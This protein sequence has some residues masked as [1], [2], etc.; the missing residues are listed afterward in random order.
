[1]QK[2]ESIIVYHS[3]QGQLSDEFWHDHPEAA[4]VFGAAILLFVA[5]VCLWEF[6]S[7]FIRNRRR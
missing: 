7:K 5:C 6:V 4:L 1:M 3:R 2:P